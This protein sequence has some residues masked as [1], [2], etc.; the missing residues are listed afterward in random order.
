MT[1]STE[2]STDSSDLVTTEVI[3]DDVLKVT[4]SRGPANAL[5]PELLS[6]LDE[7]CQQADDTPGI[8]FVIFES[9]LEGFFAAGADIKHMR[10]I[11]ARSFAEY[12][13]QMRAVN[14][15]IENANWISIAALDGMALGGGLELAL[16]C[17]FRT[18]GPR[19]RLGLPEAGIGLLPGAGGTQRLPRL[20]GHGRAVDIV[21]TA[22]Q[23]RTQEAFDI[24]LVQRV[25]EGSALD[26][27]LSLVE[28][29]SG[30]SLPA[31]VAGARCVGAAHSMSLT[32]GI[33]LEKSS[34]EGLFTNG[35]AEEGIAAFVGK[36]APK[37]A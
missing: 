32:E 12:G 4:M 24:G 30:N 29:L 7:A 35:E 21:L 26:S 37:F 19:A 15:R 11:D 9:S 8:K 22:R 36:R 34:E 27:A 14:D 23:V 3:R 18:A 10:T 25:A 33:A 2:H 13:D 28:E 31:M 1:D 17:T 6:A 16:A 5:A 20:V